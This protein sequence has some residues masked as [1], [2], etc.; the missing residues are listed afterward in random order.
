MSADLDRDIASQRDRLDRDLAQ[1]L[2]REMAPTGPGKATGERFRIP[3]PSAA[4]TPKRAV[5]QLSVAV[6]GLLQCEQELTALCDEVVGPFK[7]ERDQ[8]TGANQPEGLPMFDRVR[9]DARQLAELAIR[10]HAR[11]EFMRGK[12]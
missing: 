3:A 5:D 4:E 1:A 11:I 8:P 7:E 12:F 10:L 2:D 6:A 9:N